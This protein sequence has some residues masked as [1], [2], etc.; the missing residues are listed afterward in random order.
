MKKNPHMIIS[1]K[2]SYPQLVG[3]IS[4]TL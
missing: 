4:N 2:P 3:K 1:R